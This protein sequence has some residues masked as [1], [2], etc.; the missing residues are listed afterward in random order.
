MTIDPLS[1]HREIKIAGAT[2]FLDGSFGALRAVQEHFGRDIV[3]ILVSVMS[4]RID[5]IASLIAIS[6]GRKNLNDEIDLIGEAII[7]EYGA[8]SDDYVRLKTEL[9]AWLTVAVA[10]KSQR[11][12]KRAEVEAAMQKDSLGANTAGSA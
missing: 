5:Q 3:T 7:D 4:L 2:Y 6:S 8:M 11:Q 12:K 1:P 10:P 9:L